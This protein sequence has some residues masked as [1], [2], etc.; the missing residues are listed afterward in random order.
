[1]NWNHYLSNSFGLFNIVGIIIG[2]TE[3]RILVCT[4]DSY[5]DIMTSAL[6]LLSAA[7]AATGVISIS[8]SVLV[9]ATTPPSRLSSSVELENF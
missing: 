6:S 3:E 9:L 7:V 4:S 2:M 8:V 5:R 1:M